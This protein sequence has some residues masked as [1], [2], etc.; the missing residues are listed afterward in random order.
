MTMFLRDLTLVQEMIKKLKF[1]GHLNCYIFC[2]QVY[3]IMSYYVCL[4]KYLTFKFN[5]YLHMLTVALM[6]VIFN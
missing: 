1:L 5:L 4:F 3:I 2:F 6:F